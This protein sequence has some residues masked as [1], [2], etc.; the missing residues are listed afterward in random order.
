MTTTDDSEVRDHTAGLAGGSRAGVV[1]SGSPRF[2]SSDRAQTLL[3]AISD[4]VL[5]VDAEGWIEFANAQ[6]EEAF[7]WPPGELKGQPV[8]V[9]VPT[10]LREAHRKDRAGY[11]A[12]PVARTMNSGPHRSAVRSDGSEFP[13]AIGLSPL[14]VGGRLL[15]VT[16]IR[17]LTEQVEVLVGHQAAEH[18]FFSAFRNTRR[19]MAVTDEDGRV[20]MSNDA[21]G[22]TVGMDPSEMAGMLVTGLV[23]E[24]DRARLEDAFNDLKDRR[25]DAFQGEY[26]LLDRGGKPVWAAWSVASADHEEGTSRTCVVD[27]EDIS[28]RRRAMDALAHEALHD[29]LTGLPN[30]VLLADRIAQAL[31]R[32]AGKVTVAAFYIDVDHF[33]Q[34]NTA[35]GHDIGDATLKELAARLK[36][37]L[38]PCDTL[39]RL[40]GDEFV[41]LVEDIADVT[42]AKVVAERLRSAGATH[43]AGASN[44]C[45]S[46]SVG[47]ALGRRGINAAGLLRAAD[48]AMY[49]AKTRGKNRFS[50][51]HAGLET[52]FTRQLAAEAVIG[53]ALD[54]GRVI[55]LYQPMISV[56]TRKIV[57]V[58]TLARIHH[59]GQLLPTSRFIGA[60]EST[61]QIME[62]GAAVLRAACL[63]QRDWLD[64]LGNAAPRQVA[65]NLSTRQVIQD[66][67]V[68]TVASALLGARLDPGN[69]AL[70]IAETALTEVTRPVGTTIDRLRRLG[71]RVGIDNFG[72]GSASLTYLRRHALDFVKVDRSLVASMADDPAAE[73]IVRSVIDVGHAL[74]L[75]IIGTGVERQDQFRIL[76]AAGCDIVQGHLFAKPGWPADLEPRP[77]TQ[78]PAN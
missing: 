25:S 26:R 4:P 36:G 27:I 35:F 22:A 23:H 17:D 33:K 39:A 64:R 40:G 67:I 38:R 76:Q 63:Q 12:D 20:L 68:E 57:G 65:V 1:R 19:G 53:Q 5:C 28:D 56:T 41:A 58:E 72:T 49:A 71:V 13:V 51:Y 10:G 73:A 42:Q 75:S 7:G 14:E 21:L 60:A 46:I 59:G 24:D 16:T 70:E 55:A 31:A 62:L 78:R 66:D 15:V 37:A 2:D 54:E 8:E 45:V 29:P 44:R 34:V 77:H 48:I 52:R 61:G 11:L 43:P 50:V 47:V 6:A 69:L 74:G 32:R 3:D 9:V 30:R 18:G